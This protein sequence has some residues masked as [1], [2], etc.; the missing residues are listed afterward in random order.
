MI[1]IKEMVYV[2]I[3]TVMVIFFLINLLFFGIYLFDILIIGS[4]IGYFSYR[5]YQSSVIKN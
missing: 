4:V 3:I 5:L 2:S 1:K